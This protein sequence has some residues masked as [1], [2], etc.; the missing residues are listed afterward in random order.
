MVSNYSKSSPKRMSLI[1]FTFPSI[2][3]KWDSHFLIALFMSKQSSKILSENFLTKFFQMRKKKTS[4]GWIIPVVL[5]GILNTSN[6]F[7]L[8]CLTWKPKHKCLW[9]FLIILLK[10]TELLDQIHHLFHAKL[11][12]E[13]TITFHQPKSSVE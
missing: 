4:Q 5:A 13:G 10:I 11:C 8:I 3:K 7:W 9:L 12:K 1:R 2:L 6:D